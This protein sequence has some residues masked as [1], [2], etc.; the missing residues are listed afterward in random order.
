VIFKRGSLVNLPLVECRRL[1]VPKPT[2]PWVVVQ[3]NDIKDSGDLLVCP[4]TDEMNW[5]KEKKTQRST[6]EKIVPKEIFVGSYKLYRKTSYVKCGNICTTVNNKN[7]LYIG[8]LMPETMDRISQK[9]RFCLDL[10]VPLSKPE[11]QKL[12]SYRL[13]R[14]L[15][16][17]NASTRRT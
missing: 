14:E 17:K 2:R 4:L 16:R 9:L 15:R 13:V 7:I 10:S 12:P 6:F 1:G 3:R 8:F 11:K 5:L